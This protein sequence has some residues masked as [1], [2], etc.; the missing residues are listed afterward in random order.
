M[1]QWRLAA[2]LRTYLCVSVAHAPDAPQRCAAR[3]ELLPP[4]SEVPVT[5]RLGQR[6]ACTCVHMDTGTETGTLLIFMARGST[7]NCM[8]NP[9]VCGCNA[10]PALIA[11]RS[12]AY[13]NT[14]PATPECYPR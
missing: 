7:W 10:Y 14:S 5:T 8:S 13:L 2:C 9:S 6:M 3:A 1:H 4:P 12:E 11:P